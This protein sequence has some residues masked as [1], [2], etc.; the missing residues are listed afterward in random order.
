[1]TPLERYGFVAVGGA[2]GAML[3]YGAA[4][5]FGARASTTFWVNITG[6]F[7]IGVLA[8]SA[9][10]PRWRLLLGAGFLGGYTT[11]STW[12]LEALLSARSDDWR[13]ALV[14]LFGSVVAGFIAV[15]AG[16]AAGTR[17]R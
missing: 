11:F 13:G 6:S 2:A 17:L 14:N 1:M 8:A 4:V 10:D 15:V 5:A 9:A 12:Q 16:Y 7:L 3:R